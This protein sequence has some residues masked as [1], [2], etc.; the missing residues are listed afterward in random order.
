MNLKSTLLPVALL[1]CFL[2]VVS[3]AQQAPPK[4]LEHSYRLTYTITVM[5][6]GKRTGVQ[7]FTMTI[8]AP[9]N[10][11]SM[12]LGEKIPVATGSYSADGKANGVQTQFTY[13]DVGLNISAT[14]TEEPNGVQLVSKLEQ[15]SVAPAP[16]RIGDVSEPIIRQMVLENTSVVAA[17]KAVVIGSLDI[18]DTARHS[19][20]EVTVEQMP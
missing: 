1:A 6:A 7:H 16:V 5:D 2:P 14:L 9:T 3:A 17:G 10:R 4:P 20:I 18:P 11:G 13:L 19:D 8:S 12:K 15:S